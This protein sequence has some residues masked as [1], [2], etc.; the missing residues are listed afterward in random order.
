MGAPVAARTYVRPGRHARSGRPQRRGWP[1]RR[2][3]LRPPGG[4]RRGRAGLIAAIIAAALVAAAIVAIRLVSGA[5]PLCQA[6]FVPAYFAPGGGWDRAVSG[7]APPA[8]MILDISGT[9]AGTAPDPAF[10]AAVRKAQAAGVTVLGY[11]G[12]SYGGQPAAAVEADVRNYRSW[13]GVSGMFLDQS[14]ASAA[15]IGYYRELARYIHQAEP[16]WTIWLN[17][18]VYP[19][20]RYMSVANVIMAFEG[21]YASYR[22]LRVPAWASHYPASRFAHTVYA[23]P[24]SELASALSL[25]RARHAGYVYV[26]DGTGANPYGALPGYWAAEG[27]KLSARC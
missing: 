15:G 21:P 10:Q 11:A 2:P 26:T 24:G 3:G 14:P 25:S 27:A 22:G 23:T 6:S 1:G 8:V 9:G 5:G 20:Q 7:A 19:D 4:A 16:G 17:P 12:T 13:Y 18:G